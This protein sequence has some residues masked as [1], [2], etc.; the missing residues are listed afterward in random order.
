MTK[1]DKTDEL[2]YSSKKKKMTRHSRTHNLKSGK[3]IEYE[4]EY[5]TDQNGEKIL[6]SKNIVDDQEDE[7]IPAIILKSELQNNRRNHQGFDLPGRKRK[8]EMKNGIVY[9][10][11][12]QSDPEEGSQKVI[13][14]IM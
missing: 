8:V 13:R 12:L 7:I 14:T 6:L 2:K 1:S 10:D 11:T 4:Y 5:D 3:E 9:E